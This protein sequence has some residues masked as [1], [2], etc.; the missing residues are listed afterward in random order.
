MPMVV[1]EGAQER[2]EYYIPSSDHYSLR[3]SGF[4]RAGVYPSL[5]CQKYPRVGRD[6]TNAA[7][8]G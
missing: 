1:A 5:S 6:P 7:S 4:K 3:S 8:L 2:L